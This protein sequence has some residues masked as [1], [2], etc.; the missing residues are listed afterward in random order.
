[1]EELT[2]VLMQPALANQFVILMTH[3]PLLDGAGR[4]YMTAH[5]LHGCENNDEL[6]KV[7]NRVRANGGRLPNL[8]VHG[9]EHKGFGGNLCIG[10][11]VNITI[12]NAGAAGYVSNY[13][14]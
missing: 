8:I 5:P 6:V 4:D 2:R 7:L 11:D 12:H 14:Y 13:L 10:G 9:H 3:Y 1:L